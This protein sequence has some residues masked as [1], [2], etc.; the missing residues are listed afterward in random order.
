MIVSE[1]DRDVAGLR[2]ER[3][4]EPDDSGTGVEDDDRTRR[5]VFDLEAGRV[6]AVPDRGRDRPGH[7]T[8][9]APEPDAH[10]GARLSGFFSGTEVT[11]V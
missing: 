3:F 5:F 4:A 9:H 8:A 2:A 7:R 6:A 10:P 1:H 11:T